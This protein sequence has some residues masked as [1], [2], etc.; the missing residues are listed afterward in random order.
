VTLD[1]NC[2]QID[3][4]L[5]RSVEPDQAFVRQHTR[6][7]L[8]YVRNVLWILMHIK[9]QDNIHLGSGLN[10]FRGRVTY[11]EV[12]EALNLPYCPVEDAIG[13]R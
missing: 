10:V 2:S 11:R 8:L 4:L 1:F 5:A 3:V 9:D 6:I 7:D 12:A 13:T